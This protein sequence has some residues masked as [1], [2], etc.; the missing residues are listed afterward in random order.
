[1]LVNKQEYD[2]L[3][4]VVEPR[5]VEKVDVGLLYTIEGVTTGEV[6][7]IVSTQKNDEKKTRIMVPMDEEMNHI[8]CCV[9][10]TFGCVRILVIVG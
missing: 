3:V 2:S 7:F 1:M 4:D 8:W 10:S 6:D 5:E 9:S